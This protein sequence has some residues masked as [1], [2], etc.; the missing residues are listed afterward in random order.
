MVRLEHEI[1]FPFDDV[2]APSR[3]ASKILHMKEKHLALK[4]GEKPKEEFDR[5]KVSILSEA[6]SEVVKEYLEKKWSSQDGL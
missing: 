2:S 4:A 3:Q 6:L 5:E 1:E